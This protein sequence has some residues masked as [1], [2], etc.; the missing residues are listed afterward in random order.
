M[1]ILLLTHNRVGLSS[2]LR[3]HALG[4]HLATFGH[5]VTLIAGR[6]EPGLRFL[7]ADMDGV[8]VIQLPDMLPT[9][10]RHGGL[11]PLDVAGR[12]RYVARQRF[13]LVHGFE[14]RPSVSWPAVWI[15]RRQGIPFV[16]DC[17]D[18]WGG[19]GIR[20]LRGPLGHATLGRFDEF[21]EMRSRRSADAVTVISTALLADMRR[22]GHP[23]ELARLVPVGADAD[24][25]RPLPGETARAAYGLPANAE[26]LMYTGHTTYDEVLLAGAFAVLARARPRAW[27]VLT[28]GELPIVKQVAEQAGVAG[29]VR[30]LGFVP[31]EHV[32]LALACGDVMILPHTNRPVNAFR[33]PNRFGDYLS[34]GK[35]TLTNLTG[36]LGRA[37]EDYQVGV[38]A[39]ETPQAMAD[40]AA[41]LFE[42]PARRAALGSRARQLAEGEFSWRARAREVDDLYARLMQG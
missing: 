2:F 32:S 1:R 31:H 16:A 26:I 40:A 4:R 34:A 24:R 11:S 12:L 6:Q 17:A 18:L 29:R 33:Y 5:S 42:D 14:P 20:S 7:S 13:D 8:L 41:A 30:H 3:A 23:A 39:A 19:A 15:R 37:I 22:M 10:L 27:L 28:G 21:W 38:C 25:I 35:P 9:R 36:D